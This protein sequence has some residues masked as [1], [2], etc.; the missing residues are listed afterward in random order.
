MLQ[1]FKLLNLKLANSNLIIKSLKKNTLGLLATISQIK[2][3]FKIIYRYH[4]SK[5]RIIFIG[6]PVYINKQL[7]TM[8]K[9]TKHLFVPHSAWVAGHIANRFTRSKI[10]HTENTPKL[11]S[12]RKLKKKSSLVVIINPLKDSIAINEHH[13]VKL[14]VIALNSKADMLNETSTY[15]I[16]VKLTSLK[17]DLNLF[18]FYSLLLSVFKTAHLKKYKRYAKQIQKYRLS[19]KHKIKKPYRSYKRFQFNANN[20]QHKKRSKYTPSYYQKNIKT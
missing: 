17:A 4:I 18:L 10:S 9:K 13:A 5:K 8:L 2:K 16:P 15:K 1:N 3:V 14:P 12:I 7:T 6:N 20:T 19:L 11:F